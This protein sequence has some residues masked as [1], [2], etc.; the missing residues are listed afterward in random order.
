MMTI[1]KFIEP[2]SGITT[3]ITWSLNGK[4]TYAFEGNILVSA[5][6]LLWTVKLLGLK[7][8]DEL[9]KLATSVEE[10]LG[11]VLIS[12]Y[13]GLGSPYWNSTARGLSGLTFAEKLAHIAKVAA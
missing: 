10:T 5:S 4:P 1:P 9:L 3:T 7:D 6:I 12:A 11:V 8:L 13:V 2:P